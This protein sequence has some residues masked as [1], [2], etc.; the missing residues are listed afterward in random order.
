MK[1]R[2]LILAALLLGAL[3]AVGCGKKKSEDTA[4]GAQ[5]TVAPAENTDNTATENGSLVDMQ[6]S[7]DEDIKNVIGDKT[8][9]SS[10][11]VIVNGT[12]ADVTGLYIRPT[13]ED[14]DDWGSELIGGLFTLKDGEKA[15]YY[16]DKDE[17]DADGNPVTSYDIRI[18]Y[19]DED[20]TD[21]YFRELPLKTITQITLRMNGEGE[22]GIPYAT[23]LTTGS[24]KE[25]STLSDVMERLGLEYDDSSEDDSQDNDNSSNGS[26]SNGNSDNNQNPQPT[27]NPTTA[28]SD[29]PQ[30]TEAP[31]PQPSS[32]ATADQAK[33][34]IGQPLANLIAAIGDANG[35][36]YENEPETGETGYH[37]YDTFTVS[38]TVDEGGNEVVAGVW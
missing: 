16:Y 26:N 23:Y 31:S 19:A 13:S 28:P 7:Q 35:S 2:Y 5:V 10:K 20:L 3:T 1:K 14:D 37:Y 36:D 6:K 34:Y 11:L 4:Q 29:N 27:A 8:D 12:G 32:N 9:T 21:C 15:L 24:R 17:K 25:V 22:D 38:T 30:P 33:Q 18:V